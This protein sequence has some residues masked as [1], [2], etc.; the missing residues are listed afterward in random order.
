[1]R[2]LTSALLKAAGQREGVLE[3]SWI[4][5]IQ[6]EGYSMHERRCT[7]FGCVGKGLKV[8]R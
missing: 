1:M 7:A 2:W 6:N 8:V 3:T 4:G 5:P